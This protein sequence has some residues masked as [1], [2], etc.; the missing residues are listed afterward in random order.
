M[1]KF[2]K[3]ILSFA[4]RNRFFIFFVTALLAVA[5]Y[6]SFKTISIDAFPDVTNTSV[7]IITQWPGRSA[8]EVEKFVTRPIEIAMNPAEKKTSIRSSSLFG[9]SVV[10]VTFDDD[11]DYNAARLQIN[12]H[13]GDAD[14]PDNVNPSIEPPYGPTGEIYRFTLTSNRKTVKELKTIEDWVVDRELKAVPGVADVNSFGGEVKTYQITINPEK[15]VQYNVT[16]LQ[17]YEAVSKSNV[18]VGGDVIDQNGQAYV[19]R[20]I[21]LLNN[22]DEIKN[23]VINNIKGTP[24][25]VKTI[26]EVTESSLP[27][28]GQVGRDK[29]PDVVEGIVVMRKGENPSEVIKN[30]KLKIHDLNTK[31]LPD[32]VK[33]NTFYD[34]EN[35]VNFATDTV[36]HN[37]AEGI[38]FVTVIVFLF[39][40]DWRTTLIV[41]LIIPL[42]LLFAFICLKLKG[43]SANLLSMGAIDFGIIIDG[44]VVMVEGIFVILDHKAKEVGM[45]NYNKMSKLG[46]IKKACLVN[47]KGI[48]FAKLIIITGLLPIFSF[49][50]VEG[51]MFSPLAW[52]LGFALLGAVILTFTFV[53]ALASVLLKKDVKEKHNIFVE[54][55]TNGAMR[56]YSVCFRARQVVFIIAITALVISL[57][58]FKL[59]GTEFLPELNEGAIYVRA[60]GPLSISLKESVKMANEMRNIFLSFD[61]VKQVMSQTGRPNDGTDATGFYNIEF[62]VDIYPESQWKRKETKE[63]LIQRMQEKLKFYPGIDINFSQPISDNVEEAVSGVKG[64]IVVK[65]FGDDYKYIEKQEVNIYSILKKVDGIQ[66][67]GILHNVGQPELQIDLN[68]SEMAQYGVTAAD[69]NAV[70]EMA[71]GGKAV[72]QIYEGE[73]KFDLRIRYPEDFRNNELSIGDLRVP[74][75]SGNTVPLR[76][77]A[78]IKRTTG[79]SMI[80]RDDHQR[81]GAIK[82]SIRGRDMGS[83]VK[84]AQDKVDAAIKLP[85]GYSLQWAGDFENQQRA[86]KR[87]SQVV[88]I[89]LLVIFFI[90]FILFGNFRDSLLVLNNVPFAIM[91]GILALL[92]TGVNFNISAGIGFIA[93]FGICVQNGVILISKF[94]ANITELKHHTTWTSFA[95][96]LKAGV[97]DRLRPVVMTAMMAAIGLLPAAISH[98]IGSE[99]SKPLAIVVIGG[100]ITNTIFNLFVF[101][102]VFFWS[103]RKRVESGAVIRTKN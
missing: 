49:Q 18:N 20:G 95:V 23:I 48:F 102:I 24:I 61:E 77:I 3:N 88:P 10:K 80:Y 40:A 14:L 78:N 21:G 32:D 29:D 17:L 82:F 54:A 94:K 71:I 53:P 6:I 13:I 15:A 73:K 16:P 69:A 51:K 12:N 28:L 99:A 84:E 41:S 46:L 2:I 86:T 72:T 45:E 89:S 34:R 91:G 47:G 52:T 79:I 100:L 74:T 64:S 93:L 85:K 70:I 4:L 1:N 33:L 98:G 38:I 76:E 37:M 97:A 9:L 103:Y 30:L 92:I 22:I 83:T 55:L 31:I 56:F 67:L 42:A 87:L 36:L 68:Q 5:G 57:G 7:T 39:M 66:D 65:M 26:A 63:E 11:V 19:V 25:Y 62:H 27:R 59:L 81:Y 60:T 35:L 90:L 96:A 50:K 8:E 101:P 43:M 44:A 58:C 75:L